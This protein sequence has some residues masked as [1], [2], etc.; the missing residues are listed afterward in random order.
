[1]ANLTEISNWEDGIYRIETSDPV[2]GGEEGIANKSIKQLAN[3]TK[4]LKGQVDNIN[5]ER[6]GYATKTSPAFIGVPT[7]PTAAASTNNAQIATTA[8]VKTAIAALVGSAPAALDTLEELARALAGDANLKA[9]LLAEIGKKANAT[10][11]N[12]LHDLFIGIPIPY[13]LS[14]VPTGCLAMNGQRFDKTHYPKL[15]L[16]YPSGQLPDMRGE[17]IRGWDN[18]RGV[19]VRRTLL[20]AQGDAIRNITGGSDNILKSKTTANRGAFSG[21]ETDWRPTLADRSTN[22]NSINTGDSYVYKEM[23]IGFDASRVVPTANENR[24]RNI[25]YHYICLAA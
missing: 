9:T 3:R 14:T 19:D 8:F 22:L 1:M 5:R 17:F 16:K 24:P 18:G 7:A 2:L 25:A 4:Y 10:D 12:A 13:P 20:S 11:F 15:A 23:N 6:T 21:S